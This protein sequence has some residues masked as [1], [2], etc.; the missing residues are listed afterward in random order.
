MAQAVVDNLKV[1]AALVKFSH[2]V[3]AL[4][5]ALISLLVVSRTSAVSFRQFLWILIAMISARTAAMAFNRLVDWRIDSANP[6]TAKRELPQGKVT[7]FGVIS[8][9]I[10]SVAIFIFSAAMLGVHCL[11]LS[12]LVLSIL[13]LYS[14]TKRFTEYSHLVLGLSLALAPG[15]VWYAITSRFDLIPIPL[16]FSVLFWVAGFDILYS[17]QDLDFDKRNNLFSIPVIFGLKS[18]L[19]ISKLF[20]I[21]SVIF[22]F[23]FGYLAKLGLFFYTGSL[24]FSYLLFTQHRLVKEGD[25]ERINEAFFTRNALGAVILLIFTLLEIVI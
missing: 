9:I 13:F 20:H 24:I 2:T 15:A 22:L 6:R 10:F 14:Y 25:L 11:V 4:P 1:W 16:M 19:L 18:A 21:S 17:L 5:F 7:V 12:P 8:L 23:L 3:F